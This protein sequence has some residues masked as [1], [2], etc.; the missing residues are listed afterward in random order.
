MVE[1]QSEKSAGEFPFASFTDAIRDLVPHISDEYG[2]HQRSVT[3]K[4]AEHVEI[5]FGDPTK[6]VIGDAVDVDDPGELRA[7]LIPVKKFI[8]NDRERTKANGRSHGGQESC[9]DLQ[10]MH[11]VPWGVIESRNINEGHCSSI[12]SKLV[13]KFDLS[14][15]RVQ[16][17][18]NSYV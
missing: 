12:E 18:S 17:H 10:N 1:D 3:A 15:T 4:F 14:S 16:A 5:L 8:P 6:P 11:I 13:R 2:V 9:D 7:F